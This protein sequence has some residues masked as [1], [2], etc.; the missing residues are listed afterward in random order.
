MAQDAFETSRLLHRMASGNRLQLTECRRPDRAL[1]YFYTRLIPGGD[2][3]GHSVAEAVRVARERFNYQG[4]CDLN[5]TLSHRKRMEINR[6]V[7]TWDPQWRGV[8]H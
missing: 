4:I 7:K 2:L 3:F 5:L 6:R 8:Y 1:F